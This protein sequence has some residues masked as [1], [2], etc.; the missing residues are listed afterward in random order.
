MNVTTSWLAAIALA[1]CASP[2]AQAQAYP[3]KPTRIVV[4]NA[5]GTPDVFARLMAQKMAESW[6]VAVLVE[7][8]PGA[9]GNIAGQL[10]AK[11]A[12]DG[13]TVL[14]CDSPTWA[15][16]PHLGAKMPFDPLKDLAPVIQ[17]SQLPLYL[18]V[19]TSFPATNVA[20][21]IAQVRQNPGKF[22]YASN[23]SGSHHH[24]TT[25]VFKQMAGVDLLHVPYKGVASAALALISGDV[26]LAFLSYT[27][28]AQ[29]VAA[30]K[31]RILAIGSS[32]R[33]LALP[34]IPTVAESGVP[35]FDMS[36]ALGALV[37]AGTPRDIV[38]KLHSAIAAAAAHPDVA[39]KMAG[40]GV[41]NV[42]G[43]TPEQFGALMR[44]EHEKF[45]KL[46]KL[47][48]ARIE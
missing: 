48:G 17:T 25:E 24:L 7:N 23:G 39:K 45:G 36:S 11:S 27:S 35:G 29:F 6:G 31:L 18:T 41:V 43:S 26:Q 30:D 46:V 40:F 15:T 34:D 1:V 37:A 33:S 19:R 5:G 4:G 8:R 12:P 21:L 9:S 10:V 20:Q 32:Q 22:A 13:Y 3:A 28:T 2:A 42:A 47:T 44:M 16:N 14:Y 38:A